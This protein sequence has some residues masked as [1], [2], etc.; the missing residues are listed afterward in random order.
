MYTIIYEKIHL[1]VCFSALL[2]S[3]S[4]ACNFGAKICKEINQNVRGNE[5]KKR[6]YGTKAPVIE[7]SAWIL[8]SFSSLPTDSVDDDVEL[9]NGMCT[10]LLS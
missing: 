4:V 6:K 9:E 7:T 1:Y 5:E 2:F 3:S 10:K 8:S